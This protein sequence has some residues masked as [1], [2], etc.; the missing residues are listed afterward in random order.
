MDAIT[1]FWT[2]VAVR[3]PDECWE[4]MAGKE[5]GYGSFGLRRGK[6]V[7]AHRHAWELVKGPIPEGKHVLHKCDNPPCVNPRHLYIGTDVENGRD[8]AERGQAVGNF[9]IA[10]EKRQPGWNRKVRADDRRGYANRKFTDEQEQEIAAR[11]AAGG[12]S[13]NALAREHGVSQPTITAIVNR[14]T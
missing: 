11:Y 9:H 12:V 10:V 2:K 3:G 8:R 6:S 14:R 1:R 4:W 13:K 5:Y 7:R